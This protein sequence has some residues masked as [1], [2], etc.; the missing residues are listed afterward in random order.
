MFFDPKELGEHIAYRVYKTTN[1]NYV[2]GTND[3][4]QRGATYTRWGRKTCEDNATLVYKGTT[5]N[6]H[7]TAQITCAS[8]IGLQYNVCVQQ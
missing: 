7:F 4:V 6:M 2:L 3:K 1:N 8:I 5:Y